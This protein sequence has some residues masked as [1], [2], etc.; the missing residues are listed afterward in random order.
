MI[1]LGIESTAHTFG[2][3]IVTDKKKVLAN[4]KDSYTTESGGIIPAKASEH[5]VE[6]F[7]AVMKKA[8]E[9]A[10]I[11]IDDIDLISFSQ[12]P[13]IGHTLRVGG[14]IARSLAVITKKPL[15]GVNHCIAHL[16]I[17]RMLTPAKDPV[18]LYVSGANTQIIAYDGGK[19]RIFGE[20]LDGGLGNF[21]DQFARELGLGFPGGPK[22]GELASKGSKYIELPYVVKG[23][24][25]SFGGILTNVKQKLQTGKYSKE[26]LCYSL[27]ETVFAMIVEATERAMAHTGKDEL[28]L[29]GGVACNKRLQEMCRIMCQERNAK[30]YVLENQFNVDNGAMIAWLGIIMNKAGI[31]TS[32]SNAIIDPYE[33]TDDVIVKWRDDKVKR[34]KKEKK[35]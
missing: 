4:V 28:L 20:T 10:K 29:G 19:Y 21:L 9:E 5:H 34:I 26:D 2:V 30:C 18:L 13:G 17:G 32:I 25:A 1:C 6:C 15:I 22:V 7:D 8:L 3:G 23:M 31:E 12:A 11:K 33:R 35:R 27:Q 24:D 14:M 16:E